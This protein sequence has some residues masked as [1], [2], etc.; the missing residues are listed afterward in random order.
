LALPGK[1]RAQFAAPAITA[2]G[3]FALVG[4]YAALIPSILSQR[5]ALNNRALGGAVVC[6]LFVLATLAMLATRRI[7]S[8]TAMLSGLALLLV[9][10]LLLVLAQGLASLP[11]LLLATA[12]AGVSAALGYR[13]SLEVIN[14]IAPA[15]RRAEIVSTYYICS[16]I[17]NSLPVIGV[18]VLTV[19]AGSMAASIVFAGTI[20]AFTICA[21][22]M[23]ARGRTAPAGS[24]SS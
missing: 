18:G 22:L 21:L 24:R 23:G 7:A 12:C 4:F 13:G 6:E 5:L 20:A 9:A 14:E 19:L 10:L 2:F 1:V 15:E 8:R 3:T 16:F 11:L 17:G